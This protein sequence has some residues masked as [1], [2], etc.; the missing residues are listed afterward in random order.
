MR[1][2]SRLQ[3]RELLKTTPLPPRRCRP[4]SLRG[5]PGSPPAATDDSLQEPAPAGHRREGAFPGVPWVEPTRDRRSWGIL[6][7][8]FVGQ[9]SLGLGFLPLSRVAG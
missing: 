1:S 8:H 6:E 9:S 5:A 7:G 4:R 2:R 3:N